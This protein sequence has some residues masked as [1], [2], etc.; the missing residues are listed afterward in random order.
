MYHFIANLFQW[1]FLV[2]LVILTYSAN[3]HLLA[4]IQRAIYNVITTKKFVD[5]L[6]SMIDTHILHNDDCSIWA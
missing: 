5:W 2:I 6:T 1:A 3:P 4:S